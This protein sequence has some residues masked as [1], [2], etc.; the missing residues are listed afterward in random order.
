[1]ENIALGLFL[2]ISMAL[3]AKLFL[4][5]KGSFVSSLKRFAI[6]WVLIVIVHTALLK[7]FFPDIELS[8]QDVSRWSGKYYSFDC[9]PDEKYSYAAT[10]VLTIEIRKDGKNQIT[11]QLIGRTSLDMPSYKKAVLLVPNKESARQYEQWLEDLETDQLA[12]ISFSHWLKKNSA[13]Q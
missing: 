3:C 8:V 5:Y 9:P 7:I 1:V 11:A 2:L 13:N 10:N 4:G 6:C 12:G